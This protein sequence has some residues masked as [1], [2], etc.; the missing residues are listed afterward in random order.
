M[1]EE[2]RRVGAHVYCILRYASAKI[3]T[4]I[5]FFSHPSSGPA[6]GPASLPGSASG[7]ASLP[8]GPPSVTQPLPKEQSHAVNALSET[9]HRPQ[10]R[11]KCRFIVGQV[12]E[13]FAAHIM[14]V[15]SSR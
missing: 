2:A 12:I 15:N 5:A 13:S 14:E 9:P 7:A 4:A 8:A 1:V 11:P 6:C 3:L 10:K